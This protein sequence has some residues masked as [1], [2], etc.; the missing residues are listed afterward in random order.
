MKTDPWRSFINLH[1]IL[2][3]ANSSPLLFSPMAM[4]ASLLNYMSGIGLAWPL[5]SLTSGSICL[6]SMEGSA[7]VLDQSIASFPLGWNSRLQI[8]AQKDQFIVAASSHKLIFV[9]GHPR[10]TWIPIFMMPLSS[11]PPF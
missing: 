10:H 4:G 1:A 9:G 11:P 8:S 5:T 7:S 6:P 3:R 2:R